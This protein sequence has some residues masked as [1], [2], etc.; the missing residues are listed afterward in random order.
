MDIKV[1]T[2]GKYTIAVTHNNVLVMGRTVSFDVFPGALDGTTS[3]VSGTAMSNSM[4]GV[5][6]QIR[7]VPRDALQNSI[8]GGVRA[9]ARIELLRSRVDNSSQSVVLSTQV[10]PLQSSATSLDLSA[11]ILTT[12]SGVYR[13]AV[14]MSDGGALSS[15]SESIRTVLPAQTDPA[16]STLSNLHDGVCVAASEC[17]FVLQCKD[18]FGNKGTEPGERFQATLISQ[19]TNR[20]LLVVDGD[21]IFNQT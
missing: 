1:L 12:A 21:I 3:L 5:F 10:H 11:E 14:F 2:T 13:I 4:T 20:D 8:Y 18:R 6:T 17:K 9:E 19:D 16:T 7:L 15:F